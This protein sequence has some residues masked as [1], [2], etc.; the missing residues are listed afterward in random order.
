MRGEIFNI[1]GSSIFVMGGASSH[2][3]GPAKGNTDAVIGRGWWPEELPDEEEMANGLRNLAAHNNKVDYIITHCLPTTY[4]DI[5]KQ[6]EFKPDSITDYLEGIQKTVSY[7]HWYSGH[8]H[9]NIDV[10]ENI[11]VV[12]SRIIPIGDTIFESATILGSPK[13]RRHDA[14]LIEYEGEQLLG[15]VKD[16]MPWG[17]ILKHDEPYYDIELYDTSRKKPVVTVKE[18]QVIEKSLIK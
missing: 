8:Y 1:E 6:G 16:V 14:V 2:D 15:T 12:F 10:G 4:Q 11:T 13:Y 9:V 17:T 18:T 7:R 5:I 3:R